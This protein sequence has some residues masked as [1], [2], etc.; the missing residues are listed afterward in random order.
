M[1]NS[2]VNATPQEV[3]AQDKATALNWRADERRTDNRILS[4]LVRIAERKHKSKSASKPPEGE[5]NKA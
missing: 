1:E 4:A 2:T 3:E 5:V